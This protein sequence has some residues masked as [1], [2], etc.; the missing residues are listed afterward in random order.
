MITLGEWLPDQPDTNNTVVTAENC[1]PAAQ[2]YRSMNSFVEYSEA[3]DSKILG[4]FAA[5]DAADNTKLFAGDAGKLYLHNTSTNALDDV[6]KAGT[7]AYDLTDDERWRFIQFGDNVIAAGGIGEELQKFQVGTD[8][9]FSNLAGSPPKADHIAVVRDF[10]WVG[11]I[12]E[13]SGRVPFRVRWSAFNDIDSWTS[14]TDQSDFQDIPD[15]GK[16]QGLVGGEYCTILMERAIYRATYVGLPLVFQFDKVESERGC[17]FSGSVCNIGSLVFYCS[18]DG[19]YAF[20]GTRSTPIGSEKVN[21]FFLADF[22]SNYAGRMTASVDPLREVAMWSYTSVNSPS[23]QPDKILIYNY[24][25]NRWSIANVEADLIAPFFSAGYNVDGLTSIQTLV[26]NLPQTVDSRFFKG[27]QYF[28]GGALDDKIYAFNGDPMDATIVTGEIP[29]SKGKH[30]IVTRVYPY[31]DGG[32][33]TVQ[34]GTRNTTNTAVTFTAASSE[35]VDGFCP[36]RAQGRYHRVQLNLTNRWSTA[37]GIDFDG[38]EVG[39][40]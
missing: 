1:I 17:A 39:R 5:K 25:L 9:A 6:S 31:Y 24:V 33:V 8:S 16:V 29:I 21:D 4:I 35:N 28:F 32:S 12:D 19:F 11:N 36:V 20:D 18:D 30:S 34:V 26:D 7:P 10:V 15:S 27:G 37:Q 2:G 22:D 3:A 38:R 23:G 13:G 40:R 14:G